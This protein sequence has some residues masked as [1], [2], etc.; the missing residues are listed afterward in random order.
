[1]AVDP[2]IEVSRPFLGIR[3][4][5]V[6]DREGLRGLGR[7]LQHPLFKRQAASLSL[8]LEYGFLVRW[9]IE[10]DRHDYRLRLI[11]GIAISIHQVSMAVSENRRSRHFAESIGLNAIP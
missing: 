4:L 5:Q 8:R 6:G 11:K 2:G 10:S 7:S 9:Q 3:F 1:V